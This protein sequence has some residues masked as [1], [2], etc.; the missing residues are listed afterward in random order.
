MLPAA[1]DDAC[2]LDQQGIKRKRIA[3]LQ[4]SCAVIRVGEGRA[5]GC[6]DGSHVLAVDEFWNGVQS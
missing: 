3:M 6:R 4:A 2:T 5:C 1:V